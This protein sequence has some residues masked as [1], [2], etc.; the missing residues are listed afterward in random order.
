MTTSYNHNLFD[1]GHLKTSFPGLVPRNWPLALLG[2]NISV[3]S[4]NSLLPRARL[5]QYSPEIELCPLWELEK[6]PRKYKDICG[7]WFRVEGQIW[8]SSFYFHQRCHFVVKFMWPGTA[9][10]S[11]ALR[12]FIA[13]VWAT[14]SGELQADLSFVL[15]CKL[16]NFSV[17]V[18]GWDVADWVVSS[19]EYGTSDDL[20]AKPSLVPKLWFISK[21]WLISRNWLIK[22]QK[23]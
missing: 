16:F 20:V 17:E 22:Y 6:S 11:N 10:E 4:G 9:A 3:K 21:P 15:L 12:L 2:Y 19:R 18:C 7:K 14:L 13:S 23:R 8:F 5:H 1:G